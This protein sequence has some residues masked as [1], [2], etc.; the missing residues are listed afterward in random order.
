MP[1]RLLHRTA[2]LALAIS[3]SGPAHAALTLLYAQDAGCAH[4]GTGSTEYS[5][6]PT[7]GFELADDVTVPAGDAWSVTRVLARGT[8]APGTAPAPSVSVRFYQDA[9]GKPAAT[10][11]AACVYVGLTSFTDST[12]T[13]TIDL[14][15]G[16]SLDGGAGGAHYWFS[17]QG[18]MPY[19]LN[20]FWGWRDQA[21]SGYVAHWRS[22]AGGTC[23]A[24]TPRTD[25]V[26]YDIGNP[27]TCFALRGASEEIVF[28][29][30][31]E[32]N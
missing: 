19:V 13:F 23:S 29:D 20:Q 28:R 6:A 4:G 9:G 14:P 2:L 1:S 18:R 30:G 11:I 21:Q 32:G 5:D 17:V 24:W 12:A 3:V 22:L 16:C 27:D 26:P 10:P 7:S 25:C 15:A 8:Y 31:F